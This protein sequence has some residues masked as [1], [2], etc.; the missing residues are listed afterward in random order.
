MSNSGNSILIFEQT[1]AFRVTATINLKTGKVT[2]NRCDMVQ[3]DRFTGLYYLGYLQRR[4]YK[5]RWSQCCSLAQ[6]FF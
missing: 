3:H 5:S 1:S 4:G 6:D 2:S